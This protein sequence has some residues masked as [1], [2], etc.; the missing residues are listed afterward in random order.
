MKISNVTAQ[1]HDGNT[2]YKLDFESVT[3]YLSYVETEVPNGLRD[4]TRSESRSFFNNTTF[5]DMKDN[6]VR[7]VPSLVAESEKFLDKVHFQINAS[8]PVWVLRPEGAFASVPDYL[9]GHPDCM[10]K[11]VHEHS[12]RSPVNVY[13]SISTSA[14]VSAQSIRNRGLAVTAFVRELAQSRPV[15]LFV[16]SEGGCYQGA[17]IVI[18]TVDISNILESLSSLVYVLSAVEFARYCSLAVDSAKYNSG[19]SWGYDVHNDIVYNQNGW[20]RKNIRDILQCNDNDVVIPPMYLYDPDSKLWDNEP[21]TW[22]Q[23]M[24]DVYEKTECN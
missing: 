19:G 13:V 23:K 16:F 14:R 21:H 11:K 5:S 12:D 15:K 24:L 22:V 6:S 3:E 20:Y 7:G 1:A 10:M 17:G 9:A 8:L 2:S 4:I 18:Q